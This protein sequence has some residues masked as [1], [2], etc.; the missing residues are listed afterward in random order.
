MFMSILLTP[1]VTTSLSMGNEPNNVYT[2]PLIAGQYMVV[3]EVAVWTSIV[4]DS[5]ILHV[6]YNITDPAWYLTEAHLAVAKSLYDIPMTRTGNPI[7][8]RFP[9][10]A[11]DLWVQSY[12]FTVNLTEVFGLQCPVDESE[13]TLY[14]AAHAVVAKVDEYGEIIRAETA[15]GKGTRF[16]NRG[17]WGMYFTYTVTCETGE[18]CYLNDDAETSWANGTPFPGA[19]W[20]MYV[21]YTGG[22]LTTDLIRAKN[23]DVGDVYIMADGGYLVVKIVLDEG[24]SISYYHIHVATSLSGIPQ[25]RAGN[26]QIG[27]FEYQGNYSEITP[28]IEL[29]LPL[30]AAEQSAGTLYVAI[31]AGVATYTCYG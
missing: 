7:P 30:D 25:N 22:E 8:G 17:N 19:S 16:T 26:P 29:Y 23:Y 5:I 21:V 1:A 3:G 9:Y 15:W 14:I 28:S 4:D 12:E 27:L 31:H 13:A 24:Y 6:L 10:K 2:T 20:A 18:M 11:Y